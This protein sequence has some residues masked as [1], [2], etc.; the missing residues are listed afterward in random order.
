MLWKLDDNQENSFN[1]FEKLISSTSVLQFYY[2]R[3]TIV[4]Q[5]DATKDGIGYCLL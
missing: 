3:Q 2:P 1:N 4:I 5:T